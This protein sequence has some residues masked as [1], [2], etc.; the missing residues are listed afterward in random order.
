MSPCTSLTFKLHRRRESAQTCMA[1]G[2]LLESRKIA[3][4]LTNRFLPAHII[5]I[6]QSPFAP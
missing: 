5:G 3:N 1:P 2:V 6:S 4:A